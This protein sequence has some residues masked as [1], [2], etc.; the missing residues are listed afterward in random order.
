VTEG[1]KRIKRLLLVAA[2]NPKK[3]KGRLNRSDD[4]EG[5][6]HAALVTAEATGGL[7]DGGGGRIAVVIGRKVNT[8]MG[9]PRINLKKKEKEASRH[10]PFI[11]PR[12]CCCYNY[13]LCS[14]SEVHATICN[15]QLFN[16]QLL[17]AAHKIATLLS[18]A[19]ELTHPQLSCY[20]V[21]R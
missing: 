15:M 8:K 1:I 2:A 9:T 20:M 16:K 7:D 10:A 14:S 6:V 11:L 5:D 17:G 13:I 18:P 12:Y 21:G 19:E 4:D 3:D